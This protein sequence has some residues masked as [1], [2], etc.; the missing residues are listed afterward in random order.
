MSQ[1]LEVFLSRF[2]H[3]MQL[4]SLGLY[5]THVL[6]RLGLHDVLRCLASSGEVGRLL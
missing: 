4:V 3:A 2:G 6:L 1:G 5:A